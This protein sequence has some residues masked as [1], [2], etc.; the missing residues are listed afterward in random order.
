MNETSSDAFDF[1]QARLTTSR[2]MPLEVTNNVD[3]ASYAAASAIR[4][5]NTG[6]DFGTSTKGRTVKAD[7]E[8]PSNSS[9]SKPVKSLEE[10]TYM[11][12]EQYVRQHESRVT[13]L[14]L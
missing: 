3:V 2:I 12:D 4:P 1:R 7:E 10:E 11:D 6:P 5:T 14:F 9:V 8:E 13:G